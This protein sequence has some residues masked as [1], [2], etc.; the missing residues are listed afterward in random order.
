MRITSPGLMNSLTALALIA[1][2]SG[3]ARADCPPDCVAGGGPAATDC[4]V[5]FSG[6]PSTTVTCNDGDPCD[7]DGVVNGSCTFGVQACTVRAA[8]S[9]VATPLDA[10]PTV[11]PPGDAA[12]ALAAALAGLDPVAGGCTV[13]GLVVPLKVSVAG[14]Q[15]GKVKLTVT[16]V[17]GG[18]KDRDKL[19]LTCG[20]NTT[21][22][23]LAN[24]IQPILT[25]H[26]A[27]PQCHSGPA[28]SAGQ[29]LEAG[30]T[31][32]TDVNVRATDSPKFLRV[33]PGNIRASFLARKILGGTAV[34]ALGGAEMPQGCPGRP[35]SG[36]CLTPGE[37]YT[38]LAWI[39]G[40]A[41]NN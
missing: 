17:A 23:S 40:G 11:T 34:P 15:P 1:T 28:P 18:K 38:I 32:A 16:A 20:A 9:C 33:K 2:L 5:Q 21:V 30:H 37:I 27:I 10:P 7:Q 26:C 22:P 8:A 31:W 6:I 3:K 39:K 4:F 14:I 13:P 41:P 25:T 12:S 19:K 36:G 35:P 29:S 24:D